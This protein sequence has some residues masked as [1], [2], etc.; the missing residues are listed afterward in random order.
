MGGLRFFRRLGTGAVIAALL[1]AFAAGL[2]PLPAHAAPAA[3]APS[4]LTER[5]GLA[6]AA[7]TGPPPHTP[8]APGPAARISVTLNGTPTR[9]G[10]PL[11][12]NFSAQATA[13]GAANFTFVWAFG[14]GSSNASYGVTAS[15]G[16]ASMRTNHTF[17]T[18]GSY[19]VNVSATDNLA[20]ERGSAILLIGVAPAFSVTVN[21]TPAHAISGRPIV[22]TPVVSGGVT[23]YHAAWTGVPADCYAGTFNL[24]C[25]PGAPGNYSVRLTVSDATVDRFSEDVFLNVVPRLLVTA[26]YKSAYSCQGSTGVA[27]YNLTAAPT[28]GEPPVNYTWTIGNGV[29]TAYGSLVSVALPLNEL[30]AVTVAAVDAIGERANATLTFSTSFPA[31]GAVPPPNYAPPRALLIGGAI[32]A[33]GVVWFLGF[34][35]WRSE[36]ARRLP[37]S[38]APS[39]PA[40]ARREGAPGPTEERPDVEPAPRSWWRRPPDRS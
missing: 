15:G 2:G 20:D 16:T 7:P 40:G 3:G 31:C 39:V 14:D 32:V 33:L 34:L 21:L 36:T 25:V 37:P 29:A 17:S 6:R 5:S 8:P 35:L 30:F 23:P 9:A 24:T 18:P 19:T 1:F 38:E 26:A 10:A 4:A 12:A 28:G 22:I 27:V 11:V 13:P